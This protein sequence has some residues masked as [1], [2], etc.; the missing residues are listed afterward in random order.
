MYPKSRSYIHYLILEVTG[1]NLN[2]KLV[3]DWT[4]YVFIALIFITV[5]MHGVPL[6]KRKIVVKSSDFVP[7]SG[8]T[9]D[10]EE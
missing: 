9:P 2:E 5:L 4:L 3:I 6:V 1:L 10:K 8:T 7:Q